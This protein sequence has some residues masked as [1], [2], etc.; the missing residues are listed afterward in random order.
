MGT[1]VLYYPGIDNGL[2][3][4]SE[5]KEVSVVPWVSSWIMISCEK[6]EWRSVRSLV[7]LGVINMKEV[8]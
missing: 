4:A 6:C 8:V 7:C 1:V 5:R 2:N 3:A